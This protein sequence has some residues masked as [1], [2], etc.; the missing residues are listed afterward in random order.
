LGLAIAK[1]L[2]EAHH[3]TI[4]IESKVG[5]GTQAIIT[6]PAPKKRI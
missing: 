3:G 5:K 4:K 1:T 2:I 6:L